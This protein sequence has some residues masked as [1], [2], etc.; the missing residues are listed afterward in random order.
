VVI[1]SAHSEYLVG[2][3]VLGLLGLLLSL[4][5][6]IF[7]PSISLSAYLPLFITN[8]FLPIKSTP[9]IKKSHLRISTEETAFCRKIPLPPWKK[10]FFNPSTSMGK[11]GLSNPLL[12]LP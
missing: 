10:W 6:S 1:F 11:F 8:L 2:F 3:P 9:L 5:F 7:F 12:S 4:S